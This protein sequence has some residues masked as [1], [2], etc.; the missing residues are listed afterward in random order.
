MATTTP[1]ADTD[2]SA[3]HEYNELLK[4]VA[5]QS[6]LDV[7]DLFAAIAADIP[8]NISPDRIHLSPAGTELAARQVA[9]SI[10]KYL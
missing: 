4:Q 8:G 1:T 7:D 3:P 2:P 10:E 9:D 5:A 6:S